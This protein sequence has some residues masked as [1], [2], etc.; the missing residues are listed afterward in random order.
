MAL[1]EQDALIEEERGAGPAR[2]ADTEQGGEEMG[3]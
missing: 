3:R 1:E 2:D